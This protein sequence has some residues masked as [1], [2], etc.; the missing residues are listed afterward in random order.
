M[1]TATI[2]LAIFKLFI[3]NVCLLL[4]STYRSIPCKPFEAKS[5]GVGT[6]PVRGCLPSDEPLQ[7]VCSLVRALC[8]IIIIMRNYVLSQSGSLSYCYAVLLPR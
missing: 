2:E 7:W 4:L 8:T 6:Y 1:E 5:R 3:E